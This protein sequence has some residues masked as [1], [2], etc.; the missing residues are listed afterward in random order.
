MIALLLCCVLAVQLD[1]SRA[2]YIHPSRISLRLLASTGRGNVEVLTKKV[3]LG[4]VHKE[5]QEPGTEEALVRAC[6]DALIDASDPLGGIGAASLRNGDN[7]ALLGEWTTLYTS[8]PVLRSQCTFNELATAKK[9]KHDIGAKS[10]LLT[11]HSVRQSIRRL[12]PPYQTEVQKTPYHQFAYDNSVQFSFENRPDVEGVMTTRGY[13]S[14][15]PLD[16]C[17]LMVTFFSQECAAIETEHDVAFASLSGDWPAVTEVNFS[18]HSDVCYLDQ[19]LRVMRGA[20]GSLYI[21][22]KVE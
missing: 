7:T 9:D 5:Q 1:A 12:P 21:L 8:Q 6:L 11:I 4:L 20:M 17:R 22:Q 14:C 13:A 19:D 2:F 15:S 3:L 10:A 16:P 18:S